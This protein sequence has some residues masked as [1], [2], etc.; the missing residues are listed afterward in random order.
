[1]RSH[2]VSWLVSELGSVL[3]SPFSLLLLTYSIRNRIRAIGN[4]AR[5]R[6]FWHRCSSVCSRIGQQHR[7]QQVDVTQIGPEHK[8]H[9]L[10]CVQRPAHQVSPHS[11]V[12]RLAGVRYQLDE[13]LCRLG[14]STMVDIRRIP[15]SAGPVSMPV[16]MPFVET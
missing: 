7:A 3:K 9:S 5:Q 4:S 8:E 10:R 16:P 14:S 2:F 15:S 6:C 1:M 13:L 11:V 12:R